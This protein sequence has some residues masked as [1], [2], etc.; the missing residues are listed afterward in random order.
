MDSQSEKGERV[1]KALNFSDAIYSNSFSEYESTEGNVDVAGISGNTASIQSSY[2]TIN[3]EQLS[4]KVPEDS[5]LKIPL[6]SIEDVL[7]LFSNDSVQSNLLQDKPIYIPLRLNTRTRKSS[8]KP[9]PPRYIPR[10]LPS[11]SSYNDA[12]TA[13][14]DFGEQLMLP[15]AHVLPLASLPSSYLLTFPASSLPASYLLTFSEGSGP[16]LCP[17]KTLPVTLCS[18]QNP[19]PNSPLLSI[20]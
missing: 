2:Y 5:P 18:A 4:E 9:N 13:N 17:L 8:S 6:C 19:L 10:D 15:S 14:L 20:N 16:S 11:L 1:C 3:D 12:K 7:E